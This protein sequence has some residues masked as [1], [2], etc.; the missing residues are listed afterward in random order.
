[1]QLDPLFGC[2]AA[3]PSDHTRSCWG[4]L[5]WGCSSPSLGGNKL[6]LPGLYGQPLQRKAAF[7]GASN[8]PCYAYRNGRS[9]MLLQK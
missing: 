3:G 5:P 2:C 7:Y 4:G 1:V 9:S 6:F 8:W